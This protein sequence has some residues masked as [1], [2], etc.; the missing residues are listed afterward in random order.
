MKEG[1]VEVCL[2]S[3]SQ[4]NTRCMIDYEV[5]ERDSLIGIAYRFDMR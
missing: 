2:S 3:H 1:G 5:K 4:C